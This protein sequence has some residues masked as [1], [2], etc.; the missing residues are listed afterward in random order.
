MLEITKVLLQSQDVRSDFF[1]WCTDDNREE[2]RGSVTTDTFVGEDSV[3]QLTSVYPLWKAHQAR[4]NYK[5]PYYGQCTITDVGSHY[6]VVSKKYT[7][8]LFPLQAMTKNEFVVYAMLTEAFS[9]FI[10]ENDYPQ[11]MQMMALSL[12]ISA[13]KNLGLTDL[14]DAL[15]E[16]KYFIASETC[17]LDIKTDNI[18]VDGRNSSIVLWDI[19][20]ND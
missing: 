8:L 14:S 1:T 16:A 20:Y 15:T 4:Y 19:L 11:E 9:E 10:A 5:N 13:A 6:L 18:L 17:V 2:V 3:Y 12:G 7:P